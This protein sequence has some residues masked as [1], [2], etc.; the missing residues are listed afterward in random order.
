MSIGGSSRAAVPR[1]RN[2]PRSWRTFGYALALGLLV[3]VLG[4]QRNGQAPSRIGPR[5]SV[6]VADAATSA[7]GPS[8][9]GEP[10]PTPAM[11]PPADA[12]PASLFAAASPQAVPSELL[13][14]PSIVVAGGPRARVEMPDMEL[15]SE[16]LLPS[17]PVSGEPAPGDGPAR[18]ASL[19]APAASLP[20][21]PAVAPSGTASDRAP[22]PRLVGTWAADRSACSRRNSAYLPMVIDEKGA[23]AGTSS[24]RFDRTRQA[25]NRWAIAATCRNGQETWTANVKLVVDGTR[26]TWSSERGTER[27]QRCR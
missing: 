23:R 4:T 22:Q 15:R 14:D 12:V 20:G 2:R 25:G 5:L 13:F 27:Y 26:L 9:V 1:A 18:T 10:G 24:C 8:S 3:V 7:R 21:E 17:E 16:T 11:G 6:T 19:P